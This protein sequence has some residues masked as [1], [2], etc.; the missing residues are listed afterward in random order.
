MKKRVISK[1]STQEGQSLVEFAVSLIV[2]LLL[3]VV[4]VDGARILFTYMALRD[5]GQEGA[6]FGSYNPDDI[7]GI[8]SRVRN[9]SDMVIGFGASNVQVHVTYNSLI[10]CVG[11]GITIRVTYLNYPLSMPFLGTFLGSQTVPIS[12]TVTD[13]ILQPRC[14]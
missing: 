4:I 7:A 6:L 8:T 9:A 10:H 2:L 5:A 1:E 11:S 12:A 3:L 14:P 13:T